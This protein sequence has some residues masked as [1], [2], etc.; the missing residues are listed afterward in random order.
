MGGTWHK[1]LISSDM[2]PQ[3]PATGNSEAQSDGREGEDE[4]EVK[5]KA[6]KQSASKQDVW[7]KPTEI[8]SEPLPV[9]AWEPQFLPCPIDEMVVDYADSVPMSREFVA[10]NVTAACGSLLSGKV[11]LSLKQN[12]PWVETPNGGR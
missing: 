6:T 1:P 10:S 9:P 5:L 12:A 3:T 4:D 2:T 11:K 8:T 7:G